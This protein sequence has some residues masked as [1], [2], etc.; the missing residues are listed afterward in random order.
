[1]TTAWNRLMLLGGLL[2]TG[3]AA[4]IIVT[5]TLDWLDGGRAGGQ[6]DVTYT[7]DL[8][9]TGNRSNLAICLTAVGVESSL[10]ESVKTSVLAAWPTVKSHDTW[11]KKYSSYPDPV[12]DAGCPGEPALNGSFRTVDVPSDYVLHLYLIDASSTTAPD[13]RYGRTLPE[14]MLCVQDHCFQVT[15]GLYLT[16]AEATNTPLLA[17]HLVKGLG[18]ERPGPVQIQDDET[19]TA[20][21]SMPPSQT[22]SVESPTGTADQ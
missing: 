1:M 10:E 18:L 8:L 7:G 15:T 4:A 16:P 21:P 9:V 5:L 20:L 22:P 14:E 13:F 11:V 6:P 2:A 12:V 3:V 19:P 17:A